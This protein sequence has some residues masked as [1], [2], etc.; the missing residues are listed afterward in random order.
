MERVK[1]SIRVFDNFIEIIPE[2]GVKDNSIYEVRLKD[3]KQEN[4][5]KTLDE[6]VVKFCTKMTPAYTSLESVK[7]L[8]ENCGIPDETILYHIREAS[9][10][11][12]YIKKCKSFYGKP[13]LNL[14]SEIDQ[15]QKE[16]YAKYKAAYE[17]MLRFYMDKAA[18]NGVKGTL[19]DITF[20]TTGKLPDISKL[21]AALK[22]EMD[23]WELALQG[24]SN[25][26][27]S[28]RTGVKS[29]TTSSYTA[30]SKASMPP[31]FSRRSFT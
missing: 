19:G 8:V 20:D 30:T 23:E 28:M 1:F 15:F 18:E 16:Q 6:A 24:H 5:H 3:L 29:S 14:G 13:D 26:R 11:A 9:K 21:L 31:E 17:C 25:I 12:D 10:Y 2:G 4:G 27:A 22:S 7:A